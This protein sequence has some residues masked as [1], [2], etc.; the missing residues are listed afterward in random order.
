MKL[1]TK[2]EINKNRKDQTRDLIKK[3]E[4]LSK[5]L[6]K[7]L[8]LQNNIEFDSD[9]AKKVKE[10][11]IWCDDIQIKMGKVLET[12]K[13]YEDLVENKKEEV[14]DLV[15]RKDGLEDKILDLE[16]ELT[17]LELQLTFKRELIK[18]NA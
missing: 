11:Q 15:S 12:L 14:Y 2:E 18:T 10:Y 17:G 3:N 4:R 1:F 16:E 9:K 13:V 5:S 6:R 8:S 7:V